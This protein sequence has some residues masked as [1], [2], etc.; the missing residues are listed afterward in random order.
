MVFCFFIKGDKAL[1]GNS[2]VRQAQLQWHLESKVIFAYT[3]KVLRDNMKITMSR[4]SHFAGDN[5]ILIFHLGDEYNAKYSK[6]CN[7]LS[8]K[9]LSL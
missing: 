1:S 7:C 2:T 8:L 4:S 9:V 5:C 3:E 6:S